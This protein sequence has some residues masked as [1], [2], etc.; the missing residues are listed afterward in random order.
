MNSLGIPRDA[1]G[2]PKDS[3]GI[4]VDSLGILTDSL[5]MPKDSRGIPKDSQSLPLAGRPSQAS[6]GFPDR[7]SPI[8]KFRETLLATRPA[9]NNLRCAPPLIQ[10]HPP[11]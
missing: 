4:L 6:I 1:L 5:G 2:I 7:L 11:C 8:G 9:K 3:L 10:I